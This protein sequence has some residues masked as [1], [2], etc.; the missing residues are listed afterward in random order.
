L[1]RAPAAP[2]LG[3]MR[4]AAVLV[5][6][7]WAFSPSPG[8]ARAGSAGGGLGYTL[9]AAGGSTRHGLSFEGHVHFS[10]TE[11]LMLGGVAGYAVQ[12]EGAG[13]SHLGLV[14]G[15]LLLKLDVVQ[16]VPYGT[17]DVGALWHNLSAA[18]AGLELA[19]A[20]GLGFDHLLSRELAVGA[21]VRY[22]L[23]PTDLSRFSACLSA[24]VTISYRWE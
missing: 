9:L 18:Q 22:H 15:R 13:T 12:P 17:L 4:R 11:S 24:E 1:T 19:L 10:L 3:V 20:F 2:S 16:W 5:A 7:L 14:G 6:T 21:L 23:L 8:E